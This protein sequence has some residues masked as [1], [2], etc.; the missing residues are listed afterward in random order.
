MIKLIYKIMSA[1]AG[2]R[3]MGKLIHQ[4]AHFSKS[5]NNNALHIHWEKETV[6]KYIKCSSD[7]DLVHDSL[8]LDLTYGMKNLNCKLLFIV[9][10]KLLCSDG[11]PHQ[12]AVVTSNKTPQLI[13]LV[14]LFQSQWMYKY[15]NRCNL[16]IGCPWKNEPHY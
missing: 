7:Y 10:L 9:R 2:A 13:L 4:L 14:S 6:K 15:N 3:E 1:K 8:P 11:A 12:P 16:S 5:A